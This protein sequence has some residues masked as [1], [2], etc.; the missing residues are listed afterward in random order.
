MLFA[1]SSVQ[2]RTPKEGGNDENAV[3][4]LFNSIPFIKDMCFFEISYIMKTVLYPGLFHSA[5]HISR[6]VDVAP[7]LE[8]KGKLLNTQRELTRSLMA[9]EMVCKTRMDDKDWDEDKA[10]DS[11]KDK[12]KDK[13][14]AIE[15]GKA[16]EEK[17]A[18]EEGKAAEKTDEPEKTDGPDKPTEEEREGMKLR[19]GKI[20]GQVNKEAEDDRPVELIG[21]DQVKPKEE[22]DEL[23]VADPKVI[24][25]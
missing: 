8:L 11:L 15:E 25:P 14:D 4:Q 2:L 12:D 21:S 3:I 7:E 19:S 1:T 10:L 18:I 20:V 23:A 6:M 13:K 9:L 5:L 24:E 22:S 17:I 16:A